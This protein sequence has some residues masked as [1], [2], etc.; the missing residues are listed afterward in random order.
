MIGQLFP[1][2][3]DLFFCNRAA[4]VSPFLSLIS[5]D[6]S[7]LL[8][9]QAFPWLHNRAT[10]LLPFHRDRTLQ[11]FHHDHGGATGSAVGNFRTG[12][13]R[14]ALALRSLSAGLMAYGAVG[15]EN[16]FTAFRR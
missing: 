5:E 10:K 3:G 16:L 4:V 1:H 2:G 7:N 8:V 14:I 6:V 12:Q 9:A 15:H 13:R 11:T